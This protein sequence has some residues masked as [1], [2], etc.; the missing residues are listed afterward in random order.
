MRGLINRIEK[1]P[2]RSD[3]LV[4]RNAGVAVGQQGG[5]LTGAMQTR[6]WQI[7]MTSWP[8]GVKCLDHRSKVS[9]Q[10]KGSANASDR[11]AGRF[12]SF[13]QIML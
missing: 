2:N 12:I 7:E 3:G 5:W 13:V 11:R 1:L 9:G 4:I 6:G 10:D 8:I